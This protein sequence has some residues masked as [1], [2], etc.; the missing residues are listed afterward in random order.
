MID[1]V[2]QPARLVF[3]ISDENLYFDEIT[4]ATVVYGVSSFRPGFLFAIALKHFI[5]YRYETHSY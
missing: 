5:L 4:V 2:C 3:R 1:K